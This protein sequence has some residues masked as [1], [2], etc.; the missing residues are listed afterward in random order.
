MHAKF[1]KERFQTMSVGRNRMGGGGDIH[2]REN[3][4]VLG[5]PTGLKNQFVFDI[6]VRFQV[7]VQ[8]C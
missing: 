1:H 8:M 3:I 2:D 5:L 4:R 6:N 7:R